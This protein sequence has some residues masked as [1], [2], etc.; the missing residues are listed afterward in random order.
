MRLFCVLSPAWSLVSNVVAA[1]CTLRCNETRLEISN[2]V[3]DAKT[4]MYCILNET[5]HSK[6]INVLSNRLSLTMCGL[7]GY[8]YIILIL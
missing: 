6:V 8:M 1:L 5:A 3:N 2:E 4:L 7:L